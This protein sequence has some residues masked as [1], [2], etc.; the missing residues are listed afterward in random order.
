MQI[1]FVPYVRQ[2]SCVL[3]F[4][5]MRPKHQPVDQSVAEFLGL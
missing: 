1:D 4:L 5:G 3:T 2:S